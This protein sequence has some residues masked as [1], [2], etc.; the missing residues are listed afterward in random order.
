MRGAVPSSFACP[1]CFGVLVASV[2]LLLRCP[3]CFGALASWEAREQRTENRKQ[4][5]ENQRTPRPLCIPP[6][7]HVTHCRAQATN[8]CL[9]SASCRPSD[10]GTSI[11][12]FPF[13]PDPAPFY[14][15]PTGPIRQRRH[16]P[17]RYIPSQSGHCYPQHIP[18]CTSLKT[19]LVLLSIH[20]S[21]VPSTTS[22]RASPLLIDPATTTISFPDD[23]S[24]SHCT[25]LRDTKIVRFAPHRTAPHRTNI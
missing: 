8:P 19:A 24:N 5:T 25:S 4:R 13:P 11:P 20:P 12:I 1:C 16:N 22:F 18:S 17:R 15:W 7:I 9:V 3:C 14:F 21:T 10:D 2:S 6:S 23:T